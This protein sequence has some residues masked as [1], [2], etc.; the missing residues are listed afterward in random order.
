MLRTPFLW[1]AFSVGGLFGGWVYIIQERS[2]RIRIALSAI[3][4][5]IETAFMVVFCGF[6]TGF[7]ATTT[8]PPMRTAVVMQ[9]II[10]LAAFGI[11]AIFLYIFSQK[12][13]RVR[14]GSAN[15]NSF[16][17]A[18]SVLLHAGIIALLVLIGTVLVQMTQRTLKDRVPL[19]TF[20][21]EWD[22]VEARLIAAE[23]DDEVILQP[24]TYDF[25]P[26]AG[27]DPISDV[28]IENNC[29]NNYYDVRGVRMLREDTPTASG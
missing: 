25:Y 15:A 4:L 11:G 17:S 24:F 10:V 13:A 23:P 29:L 22:Q 2:I 5:L 6:F 14:K 18:S 12:F 26:V 20:A 19:E 28:A 8:P 27:H 3:I 1:A 16:R 21:A 7:Y 9:F